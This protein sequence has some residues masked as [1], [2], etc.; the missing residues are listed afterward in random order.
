MDEEGEQHEEDALG[1][2]NYVLPAQHVKAVGTDVGVLA[3][4]FQ[5]L[6]LHLVGDQIHQPH[7]QG[8]LGED[9]E[10][11]FHHTFHL[12]DVLCGRHSRGQVI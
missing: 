4:A 10:H 9:E 1:S 3:K 8:E 11:V 6:V 12:P 5:Q 7:A 2:Q